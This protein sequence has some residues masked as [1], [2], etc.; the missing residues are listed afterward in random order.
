[1]TTTTKT[2]FDF[3]SE[4]ALSLP[5]SERIAVDIKAACTS[6]V[7]IPS[8]D[9]S[10]MMAAGIESPSARKYWQGFNSECESAE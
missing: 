10:A 9:Y 3:G 6:S 8:D 4:Y 2:E 7:A 5:A 1:M